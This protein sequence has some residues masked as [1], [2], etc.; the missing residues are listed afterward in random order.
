MVLPRFS[1][2]ICN[3]LGVFPLIFTPLLWS[4]SSWSKSS[5]V[6]GN[7]L[8]LQADFGLQSHWDTHLP[9]K[10]EPISVN[11]I[12][13]HNF[14]RFNKEYLISTWFSIT[15]LSFLVWILYHHMKE[16]ITSLQSR[17]LVPLF[18]DLLYCNC[19]VTKLEQTGVKCFYLT[20]RFVA[21]MVF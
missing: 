7:T 6:K 5:H 12:S 2:L 18:P 8:I 21:A 15:V 16:S 4:L 11:L 3:L 14:I 13:A 20:L 9:T 17:H 1:G 19:K 10:P